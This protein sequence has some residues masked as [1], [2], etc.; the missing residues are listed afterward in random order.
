MKV[1][2]E[3]VELVFLLYIAILPPSLVM[4]VQRVA[5]PENVNVLLSMSKLGGNTSGRMEKI[6]IELKDK[7]F[8]LEHSYIDLNSLHT[9]DIDVFDVPPFDPNTSLE[10]LVSVHPNHRVYIDDHL[11]DHLHCCCLKATH[12]IP[13]I[14]SYHCSTILT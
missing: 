14:S 2:V 1:V 11:A 7:P 13:L 12:V 8:T 4:G 10:E 9:Y 6:S 5:P 3:P